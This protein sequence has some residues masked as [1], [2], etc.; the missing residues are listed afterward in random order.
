MEHQAS[1]QR[2]VRRLLEQVLKQPAGR[3]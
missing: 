2:E 1:E 3:L